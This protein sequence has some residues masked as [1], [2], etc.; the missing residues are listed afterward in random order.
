MQPGKNLYTSLAP[1]YPAKYQDLINIAF[2][3][4]FT[5][6]NT[7]VHGPRASGEQ[8]LVALRQKDTHKTSLLFSPNLP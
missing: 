6:V 1:L 5:A 2:L 3:L 4:S 7:S 8:S